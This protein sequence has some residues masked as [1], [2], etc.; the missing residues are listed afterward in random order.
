MKPTDIE[1]WQELGS[2]AA[3]L[4]RTSAVEKRERVGAF[5]SNWGFLEKFLSAPE[6]KD[7]C[8]LA[9]LHLLKVMQDELLKP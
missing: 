7:V 8:Q 4:E 9:V 5:L 2:L 1:F 3:S 6:L